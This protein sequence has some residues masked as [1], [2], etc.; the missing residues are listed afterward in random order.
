MK[1]TLSLVAAFTMA[2][3]PV[4]VSAAS[5]V[6]LRTAEVSRSYSLVQPGPASGR[7]SERGT[8]PGRNFLI[9]IAA[10]VVLVTVI[11]LISNNGGPRQ[12]SP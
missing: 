1:R 9:P 10:V 3:A 5:S 6:P 2:M 4:Q 8:R 12:V 11:V 7:A